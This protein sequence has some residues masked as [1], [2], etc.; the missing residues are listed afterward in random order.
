MSSLPTVTQMQEALLSAGK[1]HHEFQE[2]YLNGVRHEQ[3]A[4]WYSAYVLGRLGNF[5]TASLLTKWLQEVSDKKEW[6]RKAAEYIL[7][8]LEMN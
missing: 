6:F 2:N 8:K 5:T 7:Q 4:M 1:T 3:W